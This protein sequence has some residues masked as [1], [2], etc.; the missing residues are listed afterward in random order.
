MSQT[1]FA[2]CFPVSAGAFQGLIYI[3]VVSDPKEENEWEMAFIFCS[4]TISIYHFPKALQ[5]SYFLFQN[6]LHNSKERPFLF[7]HK[8]MGGK[9]FI[10]DNSSQ[11][12]IVCKKEKPVGLRLQLIYAHLYRMP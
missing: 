11:L 4:F 8:Q 5:S 2:L 3:F 1:A 9:E 6:N 12:P 10:C 7:L